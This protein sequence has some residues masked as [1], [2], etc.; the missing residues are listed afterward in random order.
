MPVSESYRSFIL[1]R[2][3]V[4]LK[5]VGEIGARNMFGGV[6]IYCAGFF[7]CLIA[8]DTLYLKVD[9]SNRSDFE[10]LGMGPFKPYKD[11]ENVMQY[12]EAPADILEDDTLLQKWGAKAVAVAQNAK[13]K[14]RKKKK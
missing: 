3:E 1:E 9:D 4:A 12:Y 14:Q 7:F 2:L 13:T 8:N 10:A 6:G 11:N 5:N